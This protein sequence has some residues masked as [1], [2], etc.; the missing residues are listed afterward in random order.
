M[1][2]GEDGVVGDGDGPG[3]GEAVVVISELLVYW[4]FGN[5]LR[6]ASILMKQVNIFI[7]TVT[8]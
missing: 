8:Q 1:D 2:D 4:A 5:V 7:T 3:G 6:C